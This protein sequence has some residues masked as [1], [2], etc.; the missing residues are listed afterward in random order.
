MPNLRIAS[1]L[2]CP[3][4]S[5]EFYRPPANRRSE[6]NYCSRACMAKAF[7]GRNVGAKS[8]RWKGAVEVPCDHCGKTLSRPHWHLGQN[9]HNFCDH[10]CFAKW[11]SDNWT[12]VDNPCWRG[13]HAPYYGANWLRQ[14][15]K[16]RHRDNHECQF[17]GTPENQLRRALNVHHIRPFRF[18]GVEKYK[19]ANALSN[20]LSVCDAC[21]S[22][23]E[24]FCLTGEITDRWTLTQQGIRHLSRTKAILPDW[25]QP[26]PPDSSEQVGRNS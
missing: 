25:L 7:N 16:C 19:E 2:V 8:P 14:A 11:K 9:A 5:K 18:Y 23:L 1:N 6:A 21:H 10:S 17:C 22:H 26:Q 15:R 13:G 3:T 4:C 12:G 20:L 24:Q